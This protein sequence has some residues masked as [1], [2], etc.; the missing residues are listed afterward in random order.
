MSDVPAN[1][2]PPVIKSIAGP[3]V[4]TQADIDRL[5]AIEKAFRALVQ[6]MRSQLTTVGPL[7]NG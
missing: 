1:W 5:V 7:L 4:A 6:G 2:A 3:R